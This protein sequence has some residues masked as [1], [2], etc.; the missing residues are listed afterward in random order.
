MKNRSLTLLLLIVVLASLVACGQTA[1]QP[2]IAP[3]AVPTTAAPTSAPA[4]TTAPT[5]APAAAT[6]LEVAGA[7]VTKTL[8]LA[9]IQALPSV[10]GW[11]GIKSSTGK[12]TPPSQFKAVSL[13][14]LCALIGG[15]DP[16][17]GI[18][19]VAKDG[20]A[21]TFSYDQLTTGGFTAFDPATGDEIKN[22]GKLTVAI[23]YSMDGQPIPDDTD[24]P[25][26]LVILSDKM[27][28][29]TDGHWSVKWVRKVVLKPLAAI[30]LRHQARP[31]EPPRRT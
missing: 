25:V 10:E 3:T 14:S 24:G 16:K 19:V 28:Q 8:T 7:T 4:A 13:E 15:L 18:N 1:P 30:T 9:D 21:M 26:R 17:M 5:A 31:D 6:V 20:Y 11:A 2:T 22:P 27:N 12:I 29:V 23:A